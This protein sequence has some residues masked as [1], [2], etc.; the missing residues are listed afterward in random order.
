VDINGHSGG[1]VA[2]KFILAEFF[3][4]QTSTTFVF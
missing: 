4:F 1:I 3:E 2:M